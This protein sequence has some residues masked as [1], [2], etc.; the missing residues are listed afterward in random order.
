M[1]KPKQH[2]VYV[3]AYELATEN[4]IMDQIAKKMSGKEETDNFKIVSV[5]TVPFVRPHESRTWY[6]TTILIEEVK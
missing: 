1:S 2:I 5:I 6:L 3:T 4:Q